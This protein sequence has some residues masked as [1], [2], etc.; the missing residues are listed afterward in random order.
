[1]GLFLFNYKYMIYRENSNGRTQIK[2]QTPDG[3]A[4]GFMFKDY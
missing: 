3:C 4:R 1:M 2:L